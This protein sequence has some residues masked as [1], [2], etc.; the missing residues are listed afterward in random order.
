VLVCSGVDEQAGLGGCGV[1]AGDRIP[2]LPRV[3][4][5][6]PSARDAAVV[7]RVQSAALAFV[8]QHVARFGPMWASAPVDA[9]SV[10]RALQ[11]SIGRGVPEPDHVFAD[12]TLDDGFRGI[13]RIGVTDD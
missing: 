3:P 2:H 9:R 1:G 4:G 11:T 8:D 7:E 10:R 6:P 5:T 12:L 13:D